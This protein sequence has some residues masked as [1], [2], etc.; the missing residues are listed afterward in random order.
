MSRL[1]VAV[2]DVEEVI[3]LRNVD[4]EMSLRMTAVFDVVE[5]LSP[6]IIADDDSL[7]NVADESAV[8][9][10]ILTCHCCCFAATDDCR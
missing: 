9:M 8:V 4:V 7:L 5:M 1:N 10:L 3:S 6:T 2:P